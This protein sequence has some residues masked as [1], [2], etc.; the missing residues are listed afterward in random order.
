MKHNLAGSDAV[1]S[2][3]AF[4]Q[5]VVT[6]KPR[7]RFSWTKQKD[8]SLIVKVVDKPSEVYLWQATN[9]ESRDFRVDTIG[10]AYKSTPLQPAKDGTYQ[11]RLKKPASGYTA[12]FVELV[13]PGPGKYPFKFT[14]EVSVI[15]DFLPYKWEDAAKRYADSATK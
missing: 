14:T 5:A 9:P 3:I 11:A 10:K 12:F 8:G 7:P 15:P 6:G 1:D 2:L 4:Y 13:Y